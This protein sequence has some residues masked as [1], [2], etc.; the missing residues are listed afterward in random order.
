MIA[1]TIIP[2][3]FVSDIVGEHPLEDKISGNG[4]DKHIDEF[5]RVTWNALLQAPKLATPLNPAR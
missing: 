3:I 5:V 2:G 4:A 1:V